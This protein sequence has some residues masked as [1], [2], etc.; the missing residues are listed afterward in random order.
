MSDL[1]G[2][3]LDRS[4]AVT[5]RTAEIINSLIQQGMNFT[6]ATA[7]SIHSARDITSALKINVPCILMNGVSIYDLNRNKYIS[8]HYIPEA[9]SEEIVAAFRKNGLKCFMYKMCGEELIA[10]YT[11]FGSEAMRE[12]AELRKK[13]FNKPYIQCSDILAESDERTVYF[14]ALGEYDQLKCVQEAVDKIR[15]V[16]CAFYIDTYSGKWFLE[17]F[18]DKASKANGIR[19]LKE[20]YG[21]ERIVCF[22]D[23]LN[24]LSMFEAA[25]LRIAAG[26]ARPEVK[27]AADIV[28]GPNTR[29]GVAEWLR[30]NYITENA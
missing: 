28:I 26:N 22:G 14:N 24:D 16:G 17:I 10:F 25:D 4:A 3:L 30:N 23:N 11:S 5:P 2:T 12:F 1:D 6:F 15:G 21:F 13:R 29:D 18:S 9:A 19:Q 8:N 7:R 27:E 20:L